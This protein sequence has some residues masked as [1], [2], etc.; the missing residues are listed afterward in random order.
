MYVGSTSPLSIALAVKRPY[1]NFM[2]KEHFYASLY[3]CI[4]IKIYRNGRTVSCSY[5]RED[6]TS[7]CCTADY[8]VFSRGFDCRAGVKFLEEVYDKLMD[9][10]GAE[11]PHDICG[12]RFAALR[13]T[14]SNIEDGVK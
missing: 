4:H 3:T 7:Q 10:N 6:P 14:L 2:A 5:S 1:T 9:E 12:T 8:L 13:G 11:R